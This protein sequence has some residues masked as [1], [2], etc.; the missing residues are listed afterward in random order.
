LDP[1][2][3]PR[4]PSQAQRRSQP[5]TLPDGPWQ[6]RLQAWIAVLILVVAGVV[7]YSNTFSSPFIFDDKAYIAQKETLHQLWP[8]WTPMLNSHRPVADFSFALN[9]ALDDF[10][11][12][13]QSGDPSFAPSVG[14]LG[15]QSVKHTFH[16]WA[17]HAV[18][19]AIHV[20]AALI[21]FDFTRRT[22]SRGALALRYGQVAWGLALSVA[23]LW[24]VHPLQTESVTYVYQRFESLMGMFFLLTFYCFLR[25][26]DSPR[27]VWWYVGSVAACLLAMGSKEVAAAAPPLLLWYDRAF[28]ASGWRELLRRRWPFYA[29]LAGVLLLLALLM[30]HMR[31][32][33]ASG[34]ILKVEGVGPLEYARTQPGVILHYLRLS[35]WPQGQNL[36][37]GWP[38]ANTWLGI[39]PPLGIVLGLLGLTV[40]CAWRHPAWGFLGGWFFLILAPTSSIAPIRDLAFEH[41][42]YLSLA[43]VLAALVVGGYELLPRLPFY[44]SGTRLQQRLIQIVPL[45]VATVALGSATYV[46]N[47]VYFSPISLWRDIIAK[48][49]DHPRAYNNL[50]LMYM[51]V[52]QP[53]EVARSYQREAERLFREAIKLDPKYYD[54]H[55]NLAQI[56]TNKGREGRNEAIEHFTVC[57]DANSWFVPHSHHNLA[58][59]LLDK[60]QAQEARR[61]LEIAMEKEPKNI[62]IRNNLAAVVERTD[63]AAALE[64]YQKTLALAPDDPRTMMSMAM[65]LED[66]GRRQEAL[67]WYGQTLQHD[68]QDSLSPMVR[69]R[70]AKLLP[71]EDPRILEH[72]VLA[73]QCQPGFVD[74]R[75][76]LAEVLAR[77]G[78]TDEA[79]AH[80]RQVLRLIPEDEEARSRLQQLIRDRT[81]PQVRPASD[82]AGSPAAGSG[83]PRT[84]SPRGK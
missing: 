8:L 34:G 6:E 11:D 35:V 16:Y 46:R 45:V 4:K 28:L 39:V 17:Y 14:N 51:M 84:P 60:G 76:M 30:L 79:I 50:G 64:L 25:A 59:L 42:M 38:V 1:R 40:W 24:L 26:Q 78:Q 10:L 62:L 32:V 20:A 44:R 55:Y 48:A 7:F 69:F 70:I 22:L 29:A 71:P 5:E 19:L 27:A 63:P 67:H 12:L 58:L 82:A 83:S 68:P 73:L 52:R 13:F 31:P 47:T 9:Y 81:G 43:A 77:Q 3:D 21:L 23:L 33:Y 53:P 65:A 72:L 74:G 61:H 66:M 54:A 37:Y 75:K 18:N 49:P 57:L 80:Y 36:D 15:S 41:R 56:L 2:I